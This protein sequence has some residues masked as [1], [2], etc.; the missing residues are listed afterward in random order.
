MRADNEAAKRAPA[1]SSANRDEEHA[2]ADERAALTLRQA[3]AC[4]TR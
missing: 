3:H 1:S 2:R 4:R